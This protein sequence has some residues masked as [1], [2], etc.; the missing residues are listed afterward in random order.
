MND[1]RKSMHINEISPVDCQE[2]W[3]RLT[4]D[5]HRWLKFDVDS[6]DLTDEETIAARKLE[7]AKRKLEAEHGP[8]PEDAKIQHVYN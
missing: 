6:V 1:E 4:P 7:D 5:K 3:S 2:E 8:L